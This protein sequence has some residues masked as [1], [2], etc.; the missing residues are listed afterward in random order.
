MISFNITHL[1][2]HFDELERRLRELH[3]AETFVGYSSE[4]K[5][6]KASGLSLPYLVG[7]LSKGYSPNNL[8]ARPIFLVAGKKFK[9][10]NSKVKDTLALYLKDIKTKKSD[11]QLENVQRAFVRDFSKE[12][13]DVFGDPS[14]LASNKPSTIAQKKVN[15]ID[16][17]L[18]DTG[19]LKDKLAF[20][21]N[22]G[23]IQTVKKL[24]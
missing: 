16:S 4:Q 2:D 21:L 15:K 9:F 20:R 7:L 5:D 22:Q 3:K 19:E 6:H 12:V 11:R 23:A 8:P 18:V 1:G 14:Q 10:Q 13:L 17:P 24:G